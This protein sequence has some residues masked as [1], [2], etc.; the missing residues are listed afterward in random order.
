MN[1]LLFSCLAGILLSITAC[2]P[3]NKSIPDPNDI[4]SFV[5]NIY[6]TVTDT[7]TIV[8]ISMATADTI[9]GDTLV[10]LGIDEASQDQILFSVY[11]TAVGTYPID[12][13]PPG[14]AQG[15]LLYRKKKTSGY[16]NYIMIDGDIT[17]AVV[18][19]VAR[20]I[21]GSFNV[22]NIGA[23]TDREFTVKADFN[24]KYNP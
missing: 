23:I 14:T 7:A 21:K 15:S 20:R 16:T 22:N 24:V 18:D 9:A 4:N 6:G 1:K 17:I 13:V 3:E 8:S 11:Q 19:T 12:L 10:S 5:N 2:A